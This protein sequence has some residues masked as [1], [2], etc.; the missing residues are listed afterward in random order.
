MGAGQIA[1]IMVAVKDTGIGISDHAQ[2]RLF[3]RFNQATPKTEMTYGGSGL[4]LNVSRKICQLHGGEIGV[5]SKEG[6]GSTF[7]FFFKVRRS[8][9]ACKEDNNHDTLKLDKLCRDI[10]ILGQ[11]L[12]GDDRSTKEISIPKDPPMANIDELKSGAPRDGRTNHTAKIAHQ[13]DNNNDNHES[14]S[15][16]QDDANSCRRILVVEDN[17]IN[18]KVLSKKLKAL[19]FHITE[20]SNGQEALDLTRYD[21]FDCILMDQE[22]PVMDGNTATTKIRELEKKSGTYTPVLGVTANVRKT[23][24]TEMLDAGMDDII[25]KPYSTDHILEKIHN[26]VG[27][28]SKGKVSR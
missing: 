2:K 15:R 10:Q 12:A 3:E 14:E 9:D 21:T 24:Q 19:G 13:V 26:L 18:R 5:S 6:E 22:M 11:E 23:Q 7:G 20:A 27:V 25:H 4:G 8:F 1:Y 16:P 17:V 28:T